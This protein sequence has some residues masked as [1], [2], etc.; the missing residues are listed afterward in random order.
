MEV[1][2]ITWSWWIRAGLVPEPWAGS[3][4]LLSRPVLGSLGILSLCK[5]SGEGHEGGWQCHVESDVEI[6]HL[7]QD[8]QV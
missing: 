1:G 6:L 7:C 3:A 5:H 2:G 4:V 8:H